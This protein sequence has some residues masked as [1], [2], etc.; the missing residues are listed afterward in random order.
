MTTAAIFIAEFAVTY[1]AL[2]LT[3]FAVDL[4]VRR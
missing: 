1:I 4:A 2:H 3:A